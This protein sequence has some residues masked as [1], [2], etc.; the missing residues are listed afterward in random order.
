MKSKNYLALSLIG[1]LMGSMITFMTMPFFTTNLIKVNETATTPSAPQNNSTINIVGGHETDNIYKA[2]IAK[3]MPSVVGITTTNNPLKSVLGEGSISGLGTGVIIDSR[4]YILTNSHVVDDGAARHVTVMFD[5]AESVPAE[6]LWTDKTMDLAVI[7]VEKENLPV[8][9]LGDSDKVEVG[10]ISVAI[11]NPLGLEFQRTVTEGIIS[12]MDRTILVE[13]LIGPPS[14]MEG[15]IQT[16]AAINPGN[17]GG[18]LLNRKGQVIGINSA[19]A[20]EGEGLGFAIP[21]NVA[22]PIV[23]Q[24][25][26]NGSFQKVV[27]GVT[28]SDA[29]VYQKHNNLDF[30]IDEGAIIIKIEKDS[31]AAKNDLQVNDIIIEF[32]GKKIKER[33]DLLRQLYTIKDGDKVQA[34]VWRFEEEVKV[35]I[36]F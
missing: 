14:K 20:G 23:E 11:G 13:N 8:A 29:A 17:S 3:A 2:V 12:G 7:K 1:A 30:G 16:S 19:K 27:M 5:D 24:F 25:I 28:V 34:V 4:G 6:I 15:L 32:N 21:I 31:I 36:Q 10:D 33:E 22:K 35:E 26:K 18:P 9:E